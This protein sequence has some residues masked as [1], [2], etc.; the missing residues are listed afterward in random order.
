MYRDPQ[1]SSQLASYQ[2]RG[3]LLLCGQADGLT[4]S[5]GMCASALQL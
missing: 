1:D 3:S 4:D 5:G 2:N